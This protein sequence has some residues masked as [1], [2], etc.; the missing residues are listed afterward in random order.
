M[1]LDLIVLTAISFAHFE[2]IFP[3][4]L[5]YYSA[6]YLILKFAIFQEVMSGI[7][8]AFGIY[9]LIVALFHI[10]TFFYWFLFAWF[11]YKLTFTIFSE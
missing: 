10:S 11:M 4:I 6:G 2:I 1:I 7:D 8:A 3:T 5:L 9:I